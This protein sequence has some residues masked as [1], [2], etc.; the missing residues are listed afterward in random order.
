MAA[1]ATAFF[2]NSKPKNFKLPLL[3]LLRDSASLLIGLDLQG[4]KLYGPIP[5]L[6]RTWVP[7]VTVLILSDNLLSGRLP[8]GI[9]NCSFLN[10]LLLS[11]NRFSGTIP[12]ELPSAGRLN[13]FSV[14]NNNLE[15]VIPPNLTRF[16][17]AD[18]AGNQGLCGKPMGKCRVSNR[19]KIA[20]VLAAGVS[21]AVGSILLSLALW[22]MRVI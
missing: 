20:I 18:F 14:A 2:V 13:E 4:N 12:Y 16:D 22:R 11:N 8:V 19:K 5:S 6:I 10:V 15:G 7:Y 9:A 3:N 1:P 17:K 21:G